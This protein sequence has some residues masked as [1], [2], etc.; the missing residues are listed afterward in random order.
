M[1]KILIALLLVLLV[2]GAI[3]GYFIVRHN[4]MYIGAD[5]ALE[6][7]ISD[8]GVTR[9]ELTEK[10]TDFEKDAGLA[11]YDI[12]LETFGMENEYSIDARTGAVLYAH[13]EPRH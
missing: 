10:D 11:R 9:A 1:R 12:E 7:A 13:S 4:N 3:G 5:A 8:A 6:L 2:A